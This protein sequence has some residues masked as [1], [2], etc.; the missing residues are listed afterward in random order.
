MTL[1]PGFGFRFPDSLLTHRLNP[2]S[3]LIQDMRHTMMPSISVFVGPG[4][5]FVRID[6]NGYWD[7]SHNSTP[8]AASCTT[9]SSGN[10]SSSSIV[11]IILRTLPFC[12][13]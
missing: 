1:I 9:A 2:F 7:G 10:A 11:L 8:S 3:R 12:Y 5:Q 13:Q 4:A 6:Y